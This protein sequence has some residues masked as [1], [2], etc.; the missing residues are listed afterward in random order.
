MTTTR[1]RIIQTLLRHPNATITFLAEAVGINGIS[2][3]HHLTSLQAEGLVTAQEERHGVGRPRL[4]YSLSE[5]GVERFPSRY[6]RLTNMLLEQLKQTLPAP[7]VERLFTQ[8]A[9]EMAASYAHE[10]ES[11]T[12]E[13]KLDFI[14]SLLASEGFGLEWERKD[15]QYLLHELTCPYFHVG[16]AHP[17]VCTM[18]Q[19]IIS[20]VLSIPT[21]K[22]Q[23]ILNGDSHCTFAI[24][25][26]TEEEVKQP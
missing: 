16:Q 2:V 7:V 5:K 23:C 4:V 18:D 8:M 14:K 1:E 15:D 20:T 13:E 11:L 12:I 10:V 26:S 17:E 24:P 19:T 3:R 6:L 22:I 21:S 25:A 9:S